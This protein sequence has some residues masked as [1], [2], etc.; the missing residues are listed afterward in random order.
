VTGNEAL[1]TQCIA[2]LLGNAVKF[3]APE[4]HPRVKIWVEESG[5]MA[6][7]W[8]EDNGVGIPADA[9]EKIF[10]MFE[11]LNQNYE[12]TGIGLAIVR[13][14]AERM[15][16]KVGVE[17]EVSQGSRFWLQLIAARAIDDPKKTAVTPE[18]VPH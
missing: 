17:S 1:L 3:V 14:A 2:N 16:G 4:V 13:K 11:R 10:G 8:F 5:G 12:G 9:H 6:R 7:F 15:G 18:L